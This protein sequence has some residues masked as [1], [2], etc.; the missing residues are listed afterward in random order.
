MS[1]IVIGEE[2][3]KIKLVSKSDSDGL[4]PKGS[5]L[6]IERNNNKHI[7]RV[8]E[9]KQHEPYK[10]SP[11]IADM[12]LSPLSQ[13]QKCQN[14]IYTYRVKDLIERNDGYVDFIP[15]QSIARRSSIDE[16]NLAMSSNDKGP[17]VFVATIHAGQNHILVDNN[18]KM[19]Y[20][21]LSNEMFFHQTV[22]CG[23]T[24]SGKTVATKYLAQ[25]FI[26]EL[27][28]AVLAINVKDVDFLKMDQA[29][30]TVNKDVLNEWNELG[31][32]AY[33][34]DN[35]MVYYPS[36]TTINSLTGV[37]NEICQKITLNVKE[38]DPESLTG[39]LQGITDI[40]AYNLPNIFRYWQ[41]SM[42]NKDK[43]NEYKYKNFVKYFTDGSESRIFKTLSQNGEESEITLHK[44]TY[45]NILWNLNYALDFFDNK[46]ALSLSEEDILIPGKMSV[47]NVAGSKGIQFG[48]IIL[49][50]LLHGI[51]NA[52]STKKS[53]VPI[54]IIIDEVHQFYDTTNA[55]EALGDLDTICRTGRSQKIGIIFSSQTLSDIPRG[56]SNV[57]NTKIIFKS[58]SISAKTFG[59]SIN[60][61][62][63][64]N[65][66]KGYALAMI[67]DLP[68]LKILKFPLSFAGVME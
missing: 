66:K 59:I 12:D 34:I 43:E 60:D 53:N 6:T 40:G 11:L 45:S 55:R 8:D 15:P 39:L 38:I 9:S 52:K 19:V 4:I 13:D 3:G 24:G 23:K 62:E 21:R 67:H 1:W 49:R 68:Q 44:G 42:N 32:H 35:F 37:T 2:N 25:Y 46:D 61:N 10:P 26:E 56:L 51:V 63:I 50:Q 33:G 41:N 47:I 30:K 28:G 64:D 18:G 7:L 29:S 31:K 22:I 58:D 5:Y 54:L 27:E 16:I 14:I 57:I 48:S 65:L 20:T 36:N 17:R